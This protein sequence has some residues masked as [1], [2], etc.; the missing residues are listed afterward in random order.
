MGLKMRKIKK[1]PKCGSRNVKWVLP[2]MW[3]LW[4][5]HDCGYQGALVI[6]ECEEEEE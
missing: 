1:C 2:Q 6:E 5:C 4:E 3:S